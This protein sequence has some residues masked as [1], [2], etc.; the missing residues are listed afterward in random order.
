MDITAMP[1]VIFVI[2]KNKSYDKTP[3][4]VSSLEHST[5]PMFI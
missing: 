5:Y 2:E 3:E 4:F 1:E